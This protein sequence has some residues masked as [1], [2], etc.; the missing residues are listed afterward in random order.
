MTC[1]TRVWQWLPLL[2][3]LL[4][5]LSTQSLASRGGGSIGDG[6]YA[7]SLTTFDQHGK[8]GQVERA[9][10]AAAK[11][12]PIF[13]VAL[14][15]SVIF[16][17]PQALPCAPLDLD[18]G[19]PRFGKVSPEIMLSHSGLSA[20]G[21]LLMAA[22]QRLA[23]QH[24]YT[25][26]EYIR[27]ETFLEELSL[28]VQ[29]YTM[30]PGARPFGATILVAYV[31]TAERQLTEGHRYPAIYRVDPSG[32]VTFLGKV[33]ALNGGLED[34]T[35]RLE[36]ISEKDALVSEL[37]SALTRMVRTQ[38]TGEGPEE[39]RRRPYPILSGTLCREGLFQ[40]CQHK[41]K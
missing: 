21:R 36:S 31:P 40:V 10:E 20:D 12:P 1:G 23:I 18:D 39:P 8:L 14:E 24:E 5:Q 2:S 22:A 35:D 9:L 4:M 11:G 6:K 25:F 28:L 17:C 33:A 13:G 19:T 7:Y 34:Y 41:T 26:D 16:C 30:K 37:H 27:I 3:L 32:S 15:D 38:P 29:E